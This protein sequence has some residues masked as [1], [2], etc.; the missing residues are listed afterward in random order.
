MTYQEIKRI[1]EENDHSMI[2]MNEDGE[3][4]HVKL[5]TDE[6]GSRYEVETMQNNGWIRTNICWEDGTIEELYKKA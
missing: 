4:V 5:I 6:N 1:T 2:Y 3:Y